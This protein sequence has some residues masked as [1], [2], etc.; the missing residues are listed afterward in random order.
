MKS[1]KL[2]VV[3]G[4]HRS[5]TS[6]ITRGLQVLGVELGDNLLPPR[7][8]D[9]DKGYWEDIDLNALNIEM[10]I[11]IESGWDYVSPINEEDVN[12]LQQQGYFARATELLKRKMGLAGNFG[13]KDPRVAKLLP[14][15]KEVFSYCQLDVRYIIALRNPLSVVKSLA[16]RDNL[17]EAQSYY[18]WISYVITSLTHSANEKRALIDY[19]RLMRS[20]DIELKR[21]AKCTDLEINQVELENYKNYFLD[22]TLQHT[23]FN[24]NDLLLDELCPAIV[25]DVYTTL[26]DVATE[27]K[28]IDDGYLKDKIERWLSTFEELKSSLKMIDLEK[29]SNVQKSLIKKQQTEYIERTEW[30]QALEK[31]LKESQS[32]IKKQQT[33]Y[34]ERT[35]WAL[36]LDAIV[37]Q[38]DE[39]I[40]DLQRELSKQ[41]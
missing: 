7:K 18:L 12:L 6:A 9:N 2:I 26:L 34:I 37:K 39:L 23:V 41:K 30:A 3:L 8:G 31:E 38:R 15:W 29:K 33:E 25:S 17:E 28:K 1:S 4:M 24:C 35:E 14:F 13:F 20:P 10:L 5:G 19:D 36:S 11:A 27:N 16:K 21:I 22:L 40:H 32:L